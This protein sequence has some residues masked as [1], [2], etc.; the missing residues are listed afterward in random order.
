[1]RD[2]QLKTMKLT[3]SYFLVHKK[4]YQTVRLNNDHFRKERKME[5]VRL[6]GK[7][8]RYIYDIRFCKLFIV[9][10]F[11]VWLEI[12]EFLFFCLVIILF[13]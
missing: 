11:N 5:E 12:I 10:L 3:V 6:V 4:K 8:T 2:I 13:H 7:K 9:R 1:M